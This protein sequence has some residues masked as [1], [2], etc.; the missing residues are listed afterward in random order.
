MPTVQHWDCSS[1]SIL[2]KSLLNFLSFLVLASN[3]SD[4][5]KNFFLKIENY[6]T[7]Q[8]I[9]QTQMRFSQANV[10]LFLFVF[11]LSLM[12]LG[13]VPDLQVFYIPLSH[14]LIFFSNPYQ[15]QLQVCRGCCIYTNVH[16]AY[17]LCK[18]HSFILQN[19][20]NTVSKRYTW[21]RH[22]FLFNSPRIEEICRVKTIFLLITNYSGL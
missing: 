9:I 12:Y 6:E 13:L 20:A 1:I 4:C 16:L 17:R 10:V 19:T 21:T 14:S 8:K 15:N 22:G 7:H 3:S 11:T 5:S 2:W 18:Y